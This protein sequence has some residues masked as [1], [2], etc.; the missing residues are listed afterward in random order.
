M[1]TIEF[2]Y[3]LM[4]KTY[5]S[6]GH[7]DL[8]LYIFYPEEHSAESEKPAILFFN[9]GSFGKGPLTPAQFQHQAKYFSS[10]GLVAICVDYRNGHDEGFTPIQ[11]ICDVKSAVRWVRDH[12]AELGV[13]PNKIAVCGA[14]AGGYITVSSHMFPEIDDEDNDTDHRANALIVF[15]AVMDGVDIMTRR[16]P[17]L[18]DIAESLSPLH[19]IKPCLPPTLWM[20]G[21]AD[22]DCE[23]DQ[24]FTARMN[25]AGNEIR[26][27]T[28]EGMEHGFFNYGRHEN[29]YFEKTKREI[30]GYLR[31]IH[32]L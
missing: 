12:H 6:A 1:R 3:P 28:Y 17:E 7:R 16:Y 26:F 21:T 32:F 9:G 18:L 19:H 13:N 11:A 2:D 4:Q 5:K 23:Q 14:S 27:L 20:C 22:E 24:A 15:S 8:S 29:V 30:E 10:I 25:E 31:E